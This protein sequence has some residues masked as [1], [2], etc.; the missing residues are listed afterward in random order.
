MR[1]VVALLVLTLA[2]VPPLSAQAPKQNSV[3]G[4]DLVKVPESLYAHLAKLPAGQGILI[5][6]VAADSLG[7]RVGFKRHDILVTMGG[8]ELKDADHFARLLVA[9]GDNTKVSI[10]RGGQKVSLALNLKLEDL[11]K[12]LVKEGGF[13]DITLKAQALG[14]NE[15]SLNL[16]YYA[17]GT[18]KLEEIVLKGSLGKIEAEVRD[19]AAQKRVTPRVHQF[20]ETAIARLRAINKTK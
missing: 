20:V 10:L 15:H 3:A 1:S 5:E 13:P 4:L 12:G 16:R 9:L 17:E 7:E 18:G 14:N 11:P 19:L 8:V 6:K 2:A